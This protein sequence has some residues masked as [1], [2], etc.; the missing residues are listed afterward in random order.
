MKIGDLVAFRG[1]WFEGMREQRGIVV[2]GPHRGT[3]GDQPAVSYTVAWFGP[4]DGSLLRHLD[5]NL[6]VLSENR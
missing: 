3:S 1:G 6:K 5:F 2:D 4:G